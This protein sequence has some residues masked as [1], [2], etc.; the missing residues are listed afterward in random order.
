M[1]IGQ[2]QRL[3]RFDL[4]RSAAAASLGLAL[5]A[6]GGGH[7]DGS[8]I[9]T[10]QIRV[11]PAA[12]TLGETAK[13]TWISNNLSSCTASDAWSGVQPVRGEMDLKPEALGTDV[14]TLSC[15]GAKGV[16]T[17]SDRLVVGAESASPAA[18]SPAAAALPE[19]VPAPV[20]QAPV[21]PKPGPA[22]VAAPVATPAPAAT[23]APVAVPVPKPAVVAPKPTPA[24]APAPTPAAAPTRAAPGP[25]PSKAVASPGVATE[26]APA[27]IPAVPPS[28]NVEVSPAQVSVGGQATLSWKSENATTCAA[29]GAWSGSQALSGKRV[30]IP[31]AVGNYTYA[32]ACSSPRGTVTGFG[33]LVVEPLPP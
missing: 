19:H 29:N 14:Y 9:A 31:N 26:P 11:S 7:T 18:S 23:P 32:L 10:L 15:S 16:L 3:P 17:S 1:R 2:S 24:P 30:I 8:S 22:A 21:T 28:V 5:S 13:L 12:I 33:E 6:C 20:P 27:K 4:A 25:A